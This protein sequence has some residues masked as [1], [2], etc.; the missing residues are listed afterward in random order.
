[1]KK[2]VFLSL[3]FIA[4]IYL[5]LYLLC[6]QIDPYGYYSRQN[7]FVSNLCYVNKTAVLNNKL[8]NGNGIFLIGSSRMI[9]IHPLIIEKYTNISTYN[10]NISGV[11]IAEEILLISKLKLKNKNNRFI[12]GFDDFSV[13]VDYQKRPEILNRITQYQNSLKENNYLLSLDEIITSL[14][15]A[16]MLLRQKKLNNDYLQENETNYPYDLKKVIHDVKIGGLRN[17]QVDFEAIKKIGHLGTK[18]DIF[19]IFPKY[20]THYLVHNKY[21][22]DEK[23]FEAIRYLV[24]NTDAQIWSF[25]EFNNITSSKENFDENGYHFKPKI[26]QMIIERIYGH[27]NQNDFG[28]L[29]T[30]EN[31]D[32]Y[33]D[34][35]RLTVQ[36]EIVRK[37][38][39]LNE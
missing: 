25:Y 24:N 7:K 35:I 37:S 19:I 4:I 29:L 38:E 6:Y 11:S 31:I 18:D 14:K 10:I 1:M 21:K 23:Y 36:N 12:A 22:V 3:L 5:I 16:F 34:K 20:Q 39:L 13:S 27:S 15:T 33:L 17:Y 9:R 28:I 8:I 30:R 26:G 2:F 32:A